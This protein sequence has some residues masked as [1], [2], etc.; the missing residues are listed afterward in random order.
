[1]EGVLILFR[2]V[3]ALAVQTPDGIR[4][5]THRPAILRSRW[6]RVPFVR[7]FVAL[8]AMT[9][10]GIKSFLRASRESSEEDEELA[11]GVLAA[12]AMVSLLLAFALFKLVPLALTLVIVPTSNPVLFNA[13]DAL[14]RILI[15]ALYIVAIGRMPEIRRL[16]EYHGAEHKAI[17]AYECGALSLDA[18]KSQTR[19][20]GRCSTT[21]VML[22]LVAAVF[23]YSFTPLDLP[24][25]QL[26]AVRVSLLVPIAGISYELIRLAARHE[27]N[28]LLS[29][30][31]APG[32]WFQ[33]LTVREPDEQQLR[34]AIAALTAAREAA[35]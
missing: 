29:A 19:F 25:W 3:Y 6:L 9:G 20:L 4:I 18:A 12:T 21:F 8:L 13:F 2:D 27:G 17:N 35:S 22:V 30:L 14:A 32:F 1:M 31:L 15:I 26:V 28:V 24:F 33:R 34:V 11:P 7:G 10:I 5:E 16:F 23:V